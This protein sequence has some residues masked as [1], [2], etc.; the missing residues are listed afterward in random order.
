MVRNG[1][2]KR[3]QVT[4]YSLYILSFDEQNVET[5]IGPS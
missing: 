3:I 1:R 5:I 4:M 2:V